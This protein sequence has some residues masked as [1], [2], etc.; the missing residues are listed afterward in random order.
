MVIP[1]RVVLVN[2]Y[3]TAKIKELCVHLLHIL[4]K[5]FISANVSP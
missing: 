3:K 2:F 4:G 5:G 1:Y